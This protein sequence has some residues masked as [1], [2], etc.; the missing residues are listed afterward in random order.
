MLIAISAHS[1]LLCT[2]HFATGECG[3]FDCLTWVGT[4]R[5]VAS[6][7]GDIVSQLWLGSEECRFAAFFVV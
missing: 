1:R 7:A 2:F 3:T 4:N 6:S 5:K